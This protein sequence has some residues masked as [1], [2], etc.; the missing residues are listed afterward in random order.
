MCVDGSK[1]HHRK[2]I[3]CIIERFSFECH[4]TK[5]NQTNNYYYFPIRQVS[6]TVVKPKPKYM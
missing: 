3:Q 4:K 6:Q 5:L 1:Y 2:L